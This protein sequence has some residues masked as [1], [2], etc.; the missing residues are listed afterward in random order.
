MRQVSKMDLVVVAV[1]G[2]VL[3]ALAITLVNA[4]F[5]IHVAAIVSFNFLSIASQFEDLLVGQ[6]LH[7]LF[8][9][10]NFDFFAVAASFTNHFNILSIYVFLNDFVGSFFYSIV[11]RG[12]SALNNQFT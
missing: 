1:L 8:F 11:V 10:R 7:V 4:P 12:Y 9:S 5:H 3:F 2:L 6:L